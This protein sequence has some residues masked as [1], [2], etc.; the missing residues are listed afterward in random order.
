MEKAED[1]GITPPLITTDRS[2]NQRGLKNRK[3]AEGDYK[4]GDMFFLATDALAQWFL[5]A[6]EDG[7]KPWTLLQ[8]MTE[9]TK[10]EEL[11]SKLRQEHIMRN[12]DVTLLIIQVESGE[13]A[14]SQLVQTQSV[15]PYMLEGSLQARGLDQR[16]KAAA[17]SEVRP[18]RASQLLRAALLVALAVLTGFVWFL[19]LALYFRWL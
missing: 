1:F 14:R 19:V 11:I 13:Q 5:R 7:K 16:P 2:Y 4:P 6:C 9:A 10:L 15:T 3:I 18:S 17:R 8:Q 12:D